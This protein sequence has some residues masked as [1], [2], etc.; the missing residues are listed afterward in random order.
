VADIEGLDNASN[1][2]HIMKK[3]EPTHNEIACSFRQIGGI[4]PH[5]LC[6]QPRHGDG[7]HTFAGGV[8]GDDRVRVEWAGAGEVHPSCASIHQ[9]LATPIHT[10]LKAVLR[11]VRNGGIEDCL[12]LFLQLLTPH[13]CS[14][15]LLVR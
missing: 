9:T 1:Q 5:P 6:N 2:T 12:C 13:H 7:R 10:E 11:A 3:G 14:A 15:S 4:V 8:D